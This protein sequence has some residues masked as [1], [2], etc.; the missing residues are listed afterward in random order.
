MLMVEV[1]MF[2][3]DKGESLSEYVSKVLSII[4]KSGLPYRVNPM[5]TVIEGEWDKV[6]E[7]IKKCHVALE[8]D[9]RRI[10]TSI[11]IDYRKGGGTR[12]E[13]KIES[14]EQKI[15]KALTKY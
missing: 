1:S 6:M 8:N 3:V 7:V 5:G 9:C 2:P 4:D 11:K 10:Y 12:M 15:G 14:I 13:A